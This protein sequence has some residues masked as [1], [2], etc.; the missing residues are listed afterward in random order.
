[1]ALYR[2]GPRGRLRGR[3]PARRGVAGVRRP[4]ARRPRTAV[5]APT[6]RPGPPVRRWHGS[7]VPVGQGPLTAPWPTSASD[8]ARWR[9]IVGATAQRWDR[10][11]EL[12]LQP[13]LAAAL[14]RHPVELA[15]FG[16]ARRTPRSSVLARAFRHRDA[17]GAARRD[18]REHRRRPRRAVHERRRP[19]PA[20]GGRTRRWH[21]VR[22]R[23]EPIDR[24]RGRAAVVSR[25]RWHRSSADGLVR[26]R[27]GTS[28]PRSPTLLDGPPVS[29]RPIN[30]GTACDA[31]ATASA[32]PSSTCCCPARCRGPRSA[33]R[34]C[35]H[36][37][38]RRRD[39]R[40]IVAGRAGHCSWRHA[41]TAPYVIVA[42]RLLA[43][44]SRAG[45]W[46]AHRV[47]V[48]PCAE[49]LH[50]RGLTSPASSG[51]STARPPAAGGS[52]CC[53]GQ[54]R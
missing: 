2:H 18:G 5:R 6:G 38:P 11:G 9:R 42:H 3:A 17:A 31:G 51:S 36:R 40:P 22:G 28:R 13:V 23:R 8:G 19:H 7:L 32:P 45:A 27:C 10:S 34:E 37:P 50:R 35:R 44:V 53:T 1:M 26:A 15:R 21:A 33:C 43:Y 12:L 41:G 16:D 20:R 49:R 4:R 25:R 39:S 24:R 48:P 47:G 52:S 14:R 54:G 30:G 29:S 46:R